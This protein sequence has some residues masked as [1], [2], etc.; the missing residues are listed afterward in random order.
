MTGRPVPERYPEPED[1]RFANLF[2]TCTDSK[3]SRLQLSK[4][5]EAHRPGNGYT[6]YSTPLYWC[7]FGNC[8]ENR[9]GYNG[10]D[11][12]EYQTAQIGEVRNRAAAAVRNR[13]RES[14]AGSE[15]KSPGR[16]ARSRR[17]SANR[18]C[19]STPRWR[20]WGAVCCGRCSARASSSVTDST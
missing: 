19:S 12:Q 20:I 15:R 13:I 9:P 7:D 18:I 10:H 17:R 2:I 1:N 6:D 4:L 5:L 16:A 8:A 11:P 3:S 14:Y